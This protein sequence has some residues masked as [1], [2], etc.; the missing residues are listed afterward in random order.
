MVEY[1]FQQLAN[2]LLYN[3]WVFLVAALLLATT[4]FGINYLTGTPE[5]IWIV[6]L[7]LMM[8]LT[9]TVVYIFGLNK[10]TK[11]VE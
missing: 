7:G 3:S 5:I 9:Y 8:S 6:L 2:L 11:N 1:L 10:I 4:S